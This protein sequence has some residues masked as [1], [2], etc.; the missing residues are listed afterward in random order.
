MAK[1]YRATIAR[2]LRHRAQMAIRYKIGSNSES[3]EQ[4]HETICRSP[5][6]DPG[7]PQL[8]LPCQSWDSATT[9]TQGRCLSGR[10]QHQQRLLRPRSQRP[11]RPREARA[12]PK[13]LH[14]Q[15]GL[16]PGNLGPITPSHAAIRS[17][18]SRGLVSE[19]RVL[20]ASSLSRYNDPLPDHKRGE[21]DAYP[22]NGDLNPW[23]Y[24]S[25]LHVDASVEV[26]VHFSEG[27]AD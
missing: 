18:L 19:R 10:L 9:P 7:P 1:A 22:R 3:N 11:F 16:L 24:S 27:C 14:H 20:L 15:R 21:Y 13:R 25:F 26:G 12:V 6:V 8:R 23:S 17:V 2:N 4:G 5:L